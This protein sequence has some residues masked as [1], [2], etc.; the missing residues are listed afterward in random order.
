MLMTQAGGRD[1]PRPSEQWNHRETEILEALRRAGYCRTQ[2]LARR[3]DVSEET[4]RRNVK[5]LADRG[6]VTRV[7][8]G[9]EL[10]DTG[11]EV[12]FNHRM[13]DNTAAKT[14]IAAAAAAMIRDGES[15]F[16]DVGSTA[17]YVARALQ[18]QRSLFVVTNS[19]AVVN[20]LVGRNDNRV[21]FAGGELRVRDGCSLGEEALSYVQRFNFEHAILTASGISAEAGFTLFDPAEATIA[22]QV[23]RAARQRILVSDASKFGVRAPI[24]GVPAERIDTLV[25]DAAPPGDIAGLLAANGVELV[26]AR[27]AS[28]T[29]GTG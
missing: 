4:I 19:L 12:P 27:A 23:A 16:L 20:A 22:L 5:R 13:Q 17:A 26:V 14:R 28:E 21:F 15:I 8:G 2:D 9:V 29:A 1:A 24:S 25:T 7:H 3:L 10:R 18:H 6:L 11:A